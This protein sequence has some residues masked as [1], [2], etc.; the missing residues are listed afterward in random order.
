MFKFKLPKECKEP[1]SLHRN[2]AGAISYDINKYVRIVCRFLCK[3]VH[4]RTAG[5][6]RVLGGMR[7][8]KYEQKKLEPPSI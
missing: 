3:R 2:I 6:F 5:A 4:H 7:W 8:C 1:F